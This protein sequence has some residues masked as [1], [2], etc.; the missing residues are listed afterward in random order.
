[1][2]AINAVAWKTAQPFPPGTSAWGAPSPQPSPKGRGGFSTKDQR[3]SVENGAAFSTGDCG[4]RRALTPALS[5]RERGL[6][7]WVSVS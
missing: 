1:M 4:M 5:Q 3:R 7:E 2:A 6:S